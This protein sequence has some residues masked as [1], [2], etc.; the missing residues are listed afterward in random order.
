[1][2]N[3]ADWRERKGLRQ[4]IWIQTEFA[5]RNEYYLIDKED[6]ENLTKV[7]IKD[8][9]YHSREQPRNVV[10]DTTHFITLLKFKKICTNTEVGVWKMDSIDAAEVLLK[11][12]RNP[13]VLNLANQ[14][15]PGGGYQNGAAAQEE[16]LFRRTNLYEFLDREERFYYPISTEGGI[17]SRNVLVIR[18]SEAT[19]YA[20]SANPFYLS[21]IAQAAYNKPPI[22]NNMLIQEYAE[23]TEN[24]IRS[25]LKIGLN[26]GH[27]SFVLG[28]FGCG[29]F[30][31]PPRHIAEI[32]KKVIS[33]FDGHFIEIVFAIIEDANSTKNSSIGNFAVFEDVL[34]KKK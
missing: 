9:L 30:E 22:E 34:K 16:S 19:G 24:K 6:D 20:F 23:G 7:N 3:K 21:F 27:D 25:I 12:G 8:Q 17:Y 4:Q 11:K 15:R 29:A 2:L 1:M 32:F 14:R 28:A 5:I 33:E 18:E 10:Y 13:V 26:H 31:N